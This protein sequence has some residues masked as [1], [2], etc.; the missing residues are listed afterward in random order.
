[1]IE[2]NPIQISPLTSEYLTQQKIEKQVYD[3][4]N[5]EIYAIPFCSAYIMTVIKIKH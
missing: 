2:K 3:L 4:K 5:D 1:M